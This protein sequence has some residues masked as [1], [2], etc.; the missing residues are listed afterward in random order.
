MATGNAK[1]KAMWYFNRLRAMTPAEVVWR[2][3]QKRLQMKERK[4]FAAKERVD[5]RRFYLED[6]GSPDIL[7]NPSS[8]GIFSLDSIAPASAAEGSEAIRLLGPYSYADYRAA[9]H[10]GFQTS[11]EW[12]LAWSYDLDYKHGHT[13]GDA[14]TNWEL[15]RHFQFAVM[16]RNYWL[17]GNPEVLSEL[18][19]LFN[20]WNARN[21]F[22][23]GIS[24]T[25]P[26]E[27]AI[28][29]V[30]WMLTQTYLQMARVD[31]PMILALAKG[32]MNMAGYIDRHHS[33]H[34]S[35]NNH[36]V[37]E[38]AAL[39]MAGTTFGVENWIKKGVK[40]LDRELTR[41]NSTDGVNLESSL[42]YHGFVMEAYLLAMLALRRSGR[43]VPPHWKEM[44]G[45]MAEFLLHSLTPGGKAVEFGDADEGKI[46]DLQGGDTDY[47]S[48]LLQLAS[49]ETGRRFTDLSDHSL[50]ITAGALYTPE[51][52]SAALQV[53][54]YDGTKSSRTFARGGYSFLRSRDGEMLVGIDHAPLGFGSIA[55][56]A[57]EDAMSF[58]LFDGDT[59]V[60]T[61]SGTYLYHTSPAERD[62]LR[63]ERAHN[64]LRYP[65]HPH[66]EMLGSFL[67]GRKGTAALTRSD[68]DRPD[69][70]QTVEMSGRTFDG[71]PLQRTITFHSV[72]KRLEIT[73]RITS[74]NNELTFIIAPGTEVTAESR[75]VRAGEWVIDTGAL[76]PRLEPVNVAP[77]Y[78]HLA[79]GT[80]VRLTVPEC[81]FFTTAIYKESRPRQ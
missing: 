22:L 9:W 39:I 66:S 54:P 55:A 45:K 18:T 56:H 69:G 72:D 26:M 49:V 34:S 17:S 48:Y 73:D 13:P 11:A 68:L 40:T 58:Q 8:R 19:H 25:S 14:R 51:E 67:W 63:A 4:L 61:D 32:A 76:Q 53:P 60:L 64:T 33:R 7:G 74:P 16:A 3:R 70:R 81:G 75:L 21:P 38:M 46:I 41:Q 27:A 23:W 80:A 44:T 62:S 52:I 78:G 31:T 71:T 29:C 6:G 10:A 37:V 20:D 36:L 43:H 42:H 57:H 47:Y 65:A 28:R 1:G 77:R 2:L 24:W 15:N 35:A 59:P 5:S 30:Q 79:Q 50:C 12:P